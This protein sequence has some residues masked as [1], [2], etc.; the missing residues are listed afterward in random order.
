[1][2][3][4]DKIFIG[5]YFYFKEKG[6][7][8]PRYSA[9]LSLSTVQLFLII[10][11]ILFYKVV[12][13]MHFL[14][15]FASTNKIIVVIIMILWLAILSLIYDNDKLNHLEE[16]YL[17]MTDNQKKFCKYLGIIFQL[18]GVV[19]LFIIVLLNGHMHNV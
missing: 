1:M 6:R 10:I 9:L 17:N 8:A 11:P 13:N 4:F 16:E 19:I 7:S 2:R 3:I 18:S 12:F 14:T 15:E 5:S